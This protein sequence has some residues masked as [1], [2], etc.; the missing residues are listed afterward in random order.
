MNYPLI[1]EYIDA[2]RSAEDNFDK[3]TNLRPVLDNN[4][5]GLAYEYRNSDIEINFFY[6]EKIRL[7]KNSDLQTYI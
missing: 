6:E 1:T 3:L 4:G 7:F 2:I 5:I